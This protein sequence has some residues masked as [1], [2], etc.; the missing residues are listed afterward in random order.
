MRK[1]ILTIVLLC[2]PLALAQGVGGIFF[3]SSYTHSLGTVAT[4]TFDNDTGSYSGSTSVTISDATS[5]AAISYCTATGSDCTP[6][7]AYSTPISISVDTTHLCANASKS[8][9]TTSATKCA[10]YTIT[11]AGPPSDDFSG[12]SGG[13]SSN[14]TNL[15]AHTI[16][17]NG[18]GYA[19]GNTAWYAAEARWTGSALNDDQH[20]DIVIGSLASGTD[21][22]GVMVRAQADGAGYVA[23]VVGTGNVELDSLP[24]TTGTTAYLRTTAQC[25]NTVFTTGDTLRLSVTG[26]VLT[27]YKNG[28]AVSGCT[29]DTAPDTTKYS[30]GAPGIYI[31]RGATGADLTIDSFAAANN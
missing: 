6:G 29:Y 17:L 22:I 27:V 15:L 5:G 20:A 23:A 4:P 8:G 9:W 3:E 7:S 28:S 25:G 30:S 12:A 14:W 26:T 13:L 31:N 1:L 10:T 11:V 19:H 24:A 21:K 16:T 18:S 2:A